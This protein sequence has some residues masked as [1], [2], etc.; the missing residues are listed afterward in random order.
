MIP[1]S[2]QLN[3]DRDKI[4]QFSGQQ[5]PISKF[6]TKTILQKYLDL[7][8]IRNSLQPLIFRKI[9]LFSTSTSFGISFCNSTPAVN[10]V[11]LLLRFGEDKSTHE[12][13]VSIF[14]PAN[15]RENMGLAP[16]SFP[17]NSG[18]RMLARFCTVR[19]LPQP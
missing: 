7:E 2:S 6:E 5:L 19:N 10:P 14:T 18:A 11:P 13:Q 16:L 15:Q 12:P 3:A 9:A 8:H 17:A 1:A 4:F